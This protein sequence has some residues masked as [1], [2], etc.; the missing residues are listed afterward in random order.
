MGLVVIVISSDDEEEGGQVNVSLTAEP[1][2]KVEGDE[3]MPASHVMGLR[4]L[5][6]ATT[7]EGTTITKVDAE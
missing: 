6:A 7:M 5:R 3:D 1:T 2:M 4:L